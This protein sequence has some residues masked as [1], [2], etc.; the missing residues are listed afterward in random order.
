MGWGLLEFE[1]LVLFGFLFGFCG[2]RKKQPVS[3][4]FSGVRH[5]VLPPFQCLKGN[6]QDKTKRFC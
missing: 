2:G 1:D 6:E 3:D 4:N 5:S